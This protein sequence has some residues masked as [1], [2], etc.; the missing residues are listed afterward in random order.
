MW[1]TRTALLLAVA[2]VVGLAGCARNTP[3]QAPATASSS[4]IRVP[5]DAP[6]IASAVAQASPG[7]TIVVSP[8]IYH[9]AV[10]IDVPRL[11]LVS[12]TDTGIGSIGLIPI[13]FFLPVGV[14]KLR[15]SHREQPN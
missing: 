15:G 6:T 5:A 4:V 12:P 11:T 1:A 7:D 9:E 8:G 3:G 14:R 10:K 2:V 13:C